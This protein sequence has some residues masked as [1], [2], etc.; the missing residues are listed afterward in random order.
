MH[1]SR[2]GNQYPCAK[3]I[4]KKLLLM[5]WECFYIE[6]SEPMR[7]FNILKTNNKSI[8]VKVSELPTP[9]V[10]VQFTI[11]ETFLSHLSLR[12]NSAHD[13]SNVIRHGGVWL[14]STWEMG[15]LDVESSLSALQVDP[16]E[17]PWG[18]TVMECLQKLNFSEWIFTSHMIN[19]W[20]DYLRLYV[21]KSKIVKICFISNK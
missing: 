9:K 19:P 5:V 15:L 7:F 14:W 20:F 11:W 4:E 17:A 3:S 8:R 18:V 10:R 6:S 2:Q 13:H 16:P 12:Q 21:C 1:L